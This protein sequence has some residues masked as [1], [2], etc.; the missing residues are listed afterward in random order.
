M[1]SIETGPKE[2]IA[3]VIMTLTDLVERY[4]MADNFAVAQINDALVFADGSEIKI[5]AKATV[6]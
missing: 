5:T 6:A 2:T 3:D 4:E 1:I